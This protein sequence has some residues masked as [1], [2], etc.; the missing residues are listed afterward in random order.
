MHFPRDTLE[1]DDWLHRNGVEVS[2][3]SRVPQQGERDKIFA[4]IKRK[5]RDLYFPR[6]RA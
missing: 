5:G 1:K 4:R 3:L 2:K 6:T